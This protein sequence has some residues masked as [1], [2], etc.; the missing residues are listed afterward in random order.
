MP[1]EGL[2]ARSLEVFRSDIA[3]V[4]RLRASLSA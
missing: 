3:D 2:K 1:D 4:A